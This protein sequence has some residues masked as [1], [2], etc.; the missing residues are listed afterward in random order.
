MKDEGMK[1]RLRC[2][3]MDA[4]L[5]GAFL[6]GLFVLTRFVIWEGLLQIE[7]QRTERIT[8]RIL[9][10][11]HNEQERIG[12]KAGDWAAW[13]DAAA[14]VRGENPLF[15]RKQIPKE[16]FRELNLDFMAF[17]DKKGDLVWGSRFDTAMS[18]FFPLPR[19]LVEQL[20]QSVR[21]EVFLSNPNSKLQGLIGLKAG[22]TMVTLRPIYDPL[23]HEPPDGALIMGR[24]LDEAE[25]ARLGAQDNFPIQIR[26]LSEGPY[27]PFHIQH[28]PEAT[29]AQR[30]LVDLK[31]EPIAVLTLKVP[32]IVTPAARSI[33]RVFGVGLLFLGLAF[34]LAHQLFLNRAVL[35]RIRRLG[36]ALDEIG[37]ENLGGRVPRE[38]QDEIAALAQHI[39]AMLKA[40]EKAERA[41]VRAERLSVLYEHNTL[42][43]NALIQEGKVVFCNKTFLELFGFS[44]EKEATGFPFARLFGDTA[45]YEAL[46]EGLESEDEATLADIDLQARDGSKR[47]AMA[48]FVALKGPNRENPEIE[49]FFVDVTGLKEAQ[50]R[51]EE[52]AK[53]R[54]EV[55][56]RALNGMAVIDPVTLRHFEVNGALAEILG[57]S[58]DELLDPQFDF[59]KVFVPEDAPKVLN[60]LKTALAT[61]ASIRYEVSHQR[62]DGGHRHVLVQI[63][64]LA[65]RIG[66]ESERCLVVV[67]DIS[68]IK[69][70]SDFLEG[71]FQ[72]SPVGLFACDIETGTLLEA[73]PAFLAM[74]GY[75]QEE[76]LGK[77]WYEITPPDVVQRE[78][79]ENEA[80][81]KGEIPMIIREKVF[82]KKDGT[83]IPTV[84][85]FSKFFDPRANKEIY[86]DFAVDISE[87]K[88]AQEQ[89]DKAYRYFKTIFDTSSE[90]FIVCGPDGKVRDVNRAAEFLFGYS[91][92]EILDPGFDW[93]CCVH[94]EDLPS[95]LDA[96]E[97][98]Q[99]DNVCRRLEVRGIKK[100]GSEIFL[101][102][103]YTPI[104]AFEESSGGRL[105]LLGIYVDITETKRLE[106]H[107]RYLSFHDSLT[108]LF[109]R[110]YFEQELDRLSKGRRAPVGVIIV[111]L[112]NLKPVNDTLGHAEGDALLKRAARALREAFRA[113][114]VIARLGGDEFGVI[115]VDADKKAL[116]GSIERLQKAIDQGKENGTTPKLSISAGYAIAE[117]TPFEPGELFRAADRAMYRNKVTKKRGLTRGH[118]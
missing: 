10:R 107:L 77:T 55:F 73:N 102:A 16:T 75:S 117:K 81:L 56:E 111:D 76:L 7:N 44:S 8:E 3:L 96:L 83:E 47:V 49:A 52:E 70:Q 72:I 105:I 69:H 114:D 35:S 14:F 86:V 94:P 80:L 63:S 4:A 78:L 115:L 113:E 27:S 45:T 54:Q 57:Y 108:E 43:A 99:K 5:L 50:A 103:S 65:P 79:Q 68:D 60:A 98:V 48:R 11:I 40:L 21:F 116:E 22:L 9:R 38:G 90:M 46:M 74:L 61:K 87:I 28:V 112:D 30:T 42:T 118:L 71:L 37:Q 17:L 64:A 25:Q 66:W 106:A 32:N 41:K 51:L 93:R 1:L 39:N 33:L 101:L 89:L 58:K 109:N 12:Q 13:H 97:T 100:D 91:K 23:S 6:L 29:I 85:Y 95:I 15:I 59:L 88:K 34:I 62:K 84:L 82:F 20:H 92:E 67:S 18:S 31:G 26:P 36:E 53:Y 2:F 110:A 104:E 19:G 24:F